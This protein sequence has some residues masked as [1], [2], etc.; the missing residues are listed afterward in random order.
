MTA[1]SATGQQGSRATTFV[2]TYVR[3]WSPLEYWP[4]QDKETFLQ[5]FVVSIELCSGQKR[6]LTNSQQ[7]LGTDN[8]GV[9]TRPRPST[10]ADEETVGNQEEHSSKDNEWFQP[11]HF[12]YYQAKDASCDHGTE[13]IL[14]QKAVAY[15]YNTLRLPVER[16]NT[17][18]THG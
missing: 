8:S 15:T 9:V 5:L 11:T 1:R 17:S 4:E 3:A 16:C 14:R 12:E 2:K 6:E 13:T 10:E 7:D 18:S